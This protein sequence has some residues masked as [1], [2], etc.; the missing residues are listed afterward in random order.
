[1][2]AAREARFS[3]LELLLAQRADP[4]RRN[5]NG[6]TALDFAQRSEDKAMIELLRKA[7][8]RG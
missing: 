4:N 5:D 1:M 6:M 3:T 2:M 7:G 8:A